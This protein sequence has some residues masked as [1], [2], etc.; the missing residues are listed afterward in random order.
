MITVTLAVW[1]GLLPLHQ[2]LR[3]NEVHTVVR[4]FTAAVRECRA[5][6]DP[7]AQG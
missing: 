4:E 1:T 3:E 6:G 2:A 5:A 7:P